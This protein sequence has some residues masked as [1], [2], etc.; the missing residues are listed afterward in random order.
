MVEGDG[1][2]KRNEKGEQNTKAKSQAE[3]HE[4]ATD[5]TGERAEKS[6]PIEMGVKIEDAHGAAEL[7]PA[8]FTREQDRPANENEDKANARAQQEQTGFAIF[9]KKFQ[10]GRDAA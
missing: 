7:G 9:A 3:A 4:D 8:M 10:H 1:I 6:P 2:D 5:A